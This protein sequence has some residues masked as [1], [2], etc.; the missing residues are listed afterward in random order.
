MTPIVFEHLA[1][2]SP[3]VWGSVSLS[4][5]DRLCVSDVQ[6]CKTASV[7]L[8]SSTHHDHHVVGEYVFGVSRDKC[9][10]WGRRWGAKPN[11]AGPIVLT[12]SCLGVDFVAAI[13]PD[14]D[15]LAVQE[16]IDLQ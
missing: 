6:E 3:K 14:C 12:A 5:S 16:D 8:I 2:S 15:L 9:R 10:P 11:G 7:S 1:I 13:E 4:G